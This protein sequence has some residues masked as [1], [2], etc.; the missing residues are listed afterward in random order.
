MGDEWNRQEIYRRAEQFRAER[1]YRKAIKEY[2]KIIAVDPDDHQVHGRLAE[3]FKLNGEN[4]NAVP[5]LEKVAEGHYKDGRID[6]VIAVRKQLVEF[7]PKTLNRY[8]DLG[9]L[10]VEKGWVADA[11]DAYK[12]AI[13]VF[14]GKR[15]RDHRLHLYTSILKLKETD[16]GSRLELAK[17]YVQLGNRNTA[18]TLLLDGL[19]MMEPK[20]LRKW[21][22]TYRWQLFKIEPS[23]KNL[24]KTF[25]S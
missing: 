17:L 14:T 3:I 22:R 19:A 5:H 24:F 12:G 11:I 9:D 15:F 10:L 2:A 13:K 20:S 8:Y 21:R 7:D 6:R 1:K 25:K 23:L 18:K 16:N 4:A